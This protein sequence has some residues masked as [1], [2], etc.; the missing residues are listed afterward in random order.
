MTP[1][2][3]TPRL[4]LF[5]SGIGGLTVL[6]Q[7]RQHLPGLPCLY[8]GDLAHVPYGPRTLDEVRTLATG[9]IGWLQGQGCTH[10]AIACNTST[11]ALRDVPWDGPLP[12]VNVVD[13]LRG[14][15]KQHP[16]LR[17]IGVVANP[18]TARRALHAQVLE[19]TAP[20]TVLTTAAP[21]LVDLLEQDAPFEAIREEVA[22][23]L[24]PLKEAGV[25]AVIYGCTHYP[26]AAQAFRQVLGPDIV[27]VDSGNLVAAELTSLLPSFEGTPAPVELVTTAPGPSFLA[28]AERLMPGGAWT[29][30]VADC[31]LVPLMM[32]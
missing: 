24:L 12:L 1:G 13:P 19:E 31:G 30:R 25:E 11:A 8:V 10:I 16:E 23:A 28:W 32:V 15:L 5:D 22:A 9:L 4:G 18:V 26:L 29:H 2:E 6:R 3:W 27:L 17:R 21:A 7:V 14:W 20:V